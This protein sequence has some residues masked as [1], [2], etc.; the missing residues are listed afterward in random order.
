MKKNNKGSVG[1]T[2]LKFFLFSLII[3]AAIYLTILITGFI[4]GKLD[5]R[6]LETAHSLEEVADIITAELDKG[7]IDSVAMFVDHV[8]DSQLKQINEYYLRFG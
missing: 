4:K 5:D 2:V 1:E 7:D 6:K 8:P 3:A